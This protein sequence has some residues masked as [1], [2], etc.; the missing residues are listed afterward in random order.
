MWQYFSIQRYPI[1]E[2]ALLLF[3]SS[4]ILSRLSFW[5]EH[6]QHTNKYWAIVEWTWQEETDAL[7]KTPF[8]IL[9]FYLR[10]GI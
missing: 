10:V 5:Q 2:V 3:E 7:E 8:L 9:S 6:Y 4:L 1:S